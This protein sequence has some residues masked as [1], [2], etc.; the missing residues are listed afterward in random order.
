MVKIGKHLPEEFP[1]TKGRYTACHH[2]KIRSIRETG[3]EKFE[4]VFIANNLEWRLTANLDKTKCICAVGQP[5]NCR[6]Y[7]DTDILLH[8]KEGTT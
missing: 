6:S 1:V 8:F 7:C 2:S 5:N 3:T 4:K